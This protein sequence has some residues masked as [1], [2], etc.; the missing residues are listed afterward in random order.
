MKKKEKKG[1]VWRKRKEQ[2]KNGINKD[3]WKTE[4]IVPNEGWQVE[5]TLL[6]RWKNSKMRT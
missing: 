5:P 1:G 4:Q 3:E 6:W 2:E